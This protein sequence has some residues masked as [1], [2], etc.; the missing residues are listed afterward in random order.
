MTVLRLD[1]NVASA[2]QLLPQQGS[3]VRFVV[4]D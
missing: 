3:D 2:F 4:G 1:N